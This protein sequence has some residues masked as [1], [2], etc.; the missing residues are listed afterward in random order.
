ML[1]LNVLSAPLLRLSPSGVLI[2]IAGDGTEPYSMSLLVNRWCT[3][4]ARNLRNSTS[5]LV[6]VKWWFHVFLKMREVSS[7]IFD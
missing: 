7:S 1:V 5:E 2:G 3:W 6:E 4:V